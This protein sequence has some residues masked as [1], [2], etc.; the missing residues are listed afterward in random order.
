MKDSDRDLI[1][2][3]CLAE[4]LKSETLN[5]MQVFLRLQDYITEKQEN[6]DSKTVVKWFLNLLDGEIGRAAAI[7][8]SKNFIAAQEIVSEAIHQYEVSGE[9]IN[10]QDFIAILRTLVTKITSEAASA[11][12]ELEF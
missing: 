12:K 10:F 7:V 2:R 5:M 11:A 6:P 9:N 3:F 4:R 1:T 8:K